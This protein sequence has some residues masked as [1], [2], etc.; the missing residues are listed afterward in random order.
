[1]SQTLKQNKTEVYAGKIFNITFGLYGYDDINN[2]ETKNEIKHNFENQFKT[3]LENTLKTI[4]LKYIDLEYYSPKYYNYE[5]D[6]LDLEIEVLNK[7]IFKTYILKFQNEINDALR[8]NKSYDGYMALTVADINE[9][10]N[11]L[12]KENYSPDIIVLSTI[13]KQ[14]IDFSRFDINDYLIYE[15]NEDENL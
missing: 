13:L 2:E 4:G 5:N 8:L 9:E 15:D 7:D 14:F 6:S 10:L 3:Q 12:S 11:N 1:M